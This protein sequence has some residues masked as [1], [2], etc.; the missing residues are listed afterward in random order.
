[1][2]PQICVLMC[3]AKGK[4]VLNEGIFSNRFRY[5]EELRRMGA[6]ISVEDRRAT[7][8]GVKTFNP[9]NVRALDLRAG[10]AVVLAGLVAKGKTEIEDIFHIERGYDN[11]VG[12]LKAV[13]ADI[14]KVSIPE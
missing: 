2:G 9:S 12:K 4:S 6:L 11:L 8:D 5:I 14:E 13:G 10:V 1:M 7:V 3:M